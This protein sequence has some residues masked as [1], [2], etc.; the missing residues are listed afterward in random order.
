MVASARTRVLPQGR[1]VCKG[2]AFAHPILKN[3]GE[4]LAPSSEEWSVPFTP[5]EP[6]PPGLPS[7]PASPLAHLPSEAKNRLQGAPGRHRATHAFA[8]QAA[9]FLSC[10]H[11]SF[12]GK[13]QPRTGTSCSLPSLL[14]ASGSSQLGLTLP[15]MAK[16]YVTWANESA[17]SFS[18]IASGLSAPPS[19]HPPPG[20]PSPFIAKGRLFS[21]PRAA[22]PAQ[23]RPSSEGNTHTCTLTHTDTYSYTHIFMYTCT[24]THKHS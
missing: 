23:K 22:G 2:E 11:L 4:V 21:Q 24:H 15:A 6:H 1:V 20:P 18:C 14:P 19:S 10:S 7:C 9:P 16:S 12:G 5:T 13:Y 17:H 3:R 8:S